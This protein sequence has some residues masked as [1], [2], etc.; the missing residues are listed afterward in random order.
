MHFAARLATS[1]AIASLCVS[2]MVRAE[3]LPEPRAL[4][5]GLPSVAESPGDDA[6]PAPEAAGLRGAVTVR[7][8]LAAALLHN[9]ALAVFAW[10]TR[11]REARIL[12]AGL[13]PNPEAS[14]EVEDIGFSGPFAGVD[15][16]QV[17]L[18]LGQL[19]ELGGKRASRMRA[20]E[21]ERTLAGWDYESARLDVLTDTARAFVETLG[22]QEMVTVR[23]DSVRIAT[24]AIGIAE[25]RLRAGISPE[26]EVTRARVARDEARLEVERARLELDHSRHHLSSLWGEAH[27]QFDRVEGSLETALEIPDEEE[28]EARLSRN[29]E[30]ARWDSE[31]QSRRAALELERTRAVPNV[32]V[33]GGIRRLL[34]PDGTT[35]VGEV[36]IPL[37]F[38]N[39]NQGA[40]AEAQRRVAR[41][42][43]ERRAAELRV[44][45]AFIDAFETLH[46]LRN[47]AQGL[48][49]SILPG[50]RD[51]LEQL[52]RGYEEGRFS[53][54]DVLSAERELA[55]VRARRVEVLTKF[56]QGVADLE[57][58]L[59]APLFPE[60]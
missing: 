42:A 28:I 1:V 16:S 37:P 12:Q 17:T 30:I 47:Q 41:S 13:R 6:Q 59:A 49:T 22:A 25:A 5:R 2:S 60:P 18:R 40:I 31:E 55:A 48:E 36:A 54:L 34:G 38:W 56:H 58:L 9:P 19:V 15:S 29:P 21:L 4:G 3:G 43:A 8:A 33:I 57:R 39:R 32:T 52:R 11:A 14:L 26:V 50:M 46:G 44:H 23:E 35:F 7:R 53:Q 20:A 10:E 27:A 45:S 24:E 51:T